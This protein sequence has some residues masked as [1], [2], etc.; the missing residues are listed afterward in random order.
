MTRAFVTGITGQDGYYLTE[1]LHSKG[2][3][4]AGLVR[5]TSQPAPVPPGVAVYYEG[6]VTDYVSVARAISE[7]EPDEVYN[8]AAQSHVGTSFACPAATTDVNALGAL[9][10]F[11]ACKNYAIEARVY[12]AGTSEM[13]GGR[14]EIAYSERS[15]FHPRSPYAC[16]KVFAHHTAVNYREAYSLH[17]SN[18]ILFNHESPRRGAEFLT[19]KVIQYVTK[20]KL[21]LTTEPLRL[22]RPEPKRDWGYAPEYVEAMWLMLQ[23]PEGGDYVVGTGVS[24]TVRDF[25][26][27]AFA[28]AGLDTGKYVL[29]QTAEYRPAEVNYLRADPSKARAALGWEPRSSVRALIRI[30]LGAAL[31]TA[32]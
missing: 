19:Q 3:E 1:L 5:R 16:A 7:F 24:T 27:M 8:L 14:E 15:P 9:N 29:W 4:V 25:V 21:G 13:F 22:G 20:V 17:I 2:Y 12:Q 18:G 23:R 31:D 32:V 28:E 10:V 6:D 26:E 11:E 30:M